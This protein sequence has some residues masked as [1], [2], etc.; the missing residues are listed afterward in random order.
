MKKIWISLLVVAVFAGGVLFVQAQTAPSFATLTSRAYEQQVKAND[1]KIAVVMF[2]MG[3]CRPC[4]EAKKSVWPQIVKAY[5][6]NDQVNVFL[7][8]TD[9]DQAASDGT[10][11]HVTAGIRR[12]PTFAVL[13]NGSVETAFVGFSAGQEQEVQTKIAQLVKSHQ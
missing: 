11:L 8:P 7:F 6:G 13:F 1:G 2:T 9:K 10:H 3:G 5:E 12:M 4:F